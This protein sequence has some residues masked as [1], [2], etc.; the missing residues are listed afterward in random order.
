MFTRVVAVRTKEGKARQ[1]AKTIEEKILPILEDQTGFVDEVVL[2]SDT[3]PDQ[4]LAL[5][6]WENQEDAERYMHEHFPRVN[7]LISHLV[8]SAPVSKTFNVDA[9]SS[10]KVIAGKQAA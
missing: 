4:I 8:E 9:F 1:L 3:E 10:H 6:F 2:I 5:S 7:E